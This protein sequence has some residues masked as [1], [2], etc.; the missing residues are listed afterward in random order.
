[1]NVRVLYPT[2]VGAYRA[3]RLAAI[4]ET[5]ADFAT[6]LSA[7]SAI[8]PNRLQQRLVHTPFQRVFGAFDGERLLGMACV[9]RE[10]IAVTY[11]RAH[12]WGVYVL[13]A[14][15]GQGLGRALMDAALDYIESVPELTRVTL[16]VG[17]DNHAAKALYRT[18]GFA[19]VDAE[20]AGHADDLADADADA[21]QGQ[22]EEQM[23]LVL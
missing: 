14:A 10:P 23:L 13:R 2:D 15:R 16:M 22:R 4:E 19:A 9:K 6:T 8:A 1:M 11:D 7:E 12:V 20:R 5:P 21:E 3:L 17:V 18:L